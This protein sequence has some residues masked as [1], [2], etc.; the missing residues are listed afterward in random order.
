M[1][2]LDGP[3]WE[4]DKNQE[5][6]HRRLSQLI[7]SKQ[8]CKKK[9]WQIAMFFSYRSKPVLRNALFPPTSSGD[10]SCDDSHSGRL[11]KAFSRTYRPNLSTARALA[12]AASSSRF[13]GGAFV[14]SALRRLIDVAVISSTA[15]RN[16][17]SLAFDGLLKP[18]IFRT[19]WSAA[20]RV[21]SSVTGGSKLNSVLMFLHIPFDLTYRYSAV[22]APPYMRVFRA[23]RCR[24]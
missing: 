13:F 18:V 22:S 7:D 14:S 19:N 21:S 23:L 3:D 5:F 11:Q 15:A 17:A 10:F 4:L 24:L 16:K 9:M 2:D 1:E 20:A 6:R 12:F 8:S